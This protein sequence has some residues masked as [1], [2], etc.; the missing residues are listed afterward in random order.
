MLRGEARK[1]TGRKPKPLSEKLA[2]GNPGHRPLKKLEFGITVGFVQAMVG[3]HL[4]KSEN[5][6]IKRRKQW[7]NFL[8]HIGINTHSDTLQ[9]IYSYMPMLPTKSSSKMCQGILTRS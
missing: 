9:W 2:E 3:C 6:F 8:T 7:R 1:G 5:N 4:W